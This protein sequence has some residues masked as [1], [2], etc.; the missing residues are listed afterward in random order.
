MNR[1][2]SIIVTCFVVM[3]FS[4]N[5]EK[6]DDGLSQTSCLYNY[7]EAAINVDSF[8]P[9]GCSTY[10][11]SEQEFPVGQYQYYRPRFNPNNPNQIA[12]IQW[13]STSGTLAKGYSLH[14]FDFCTGEH[15]LLV[16]E[17][18]GFWGDYVI[19]FDWGNND[20]MVY[21]TRTE[22]FYTIKADGQDETYLTNAPSESGYYKLSLNTAGNKFLFKSDESGSMCYI[23]NLGNQS[24]DTIVE[25]RYVTNPRG[26]DWNSNNEL[27]FIANA[28]I[29]EN[30]NEHG[31][32]TFNLDNKSGDYVYNP[33]YH[34]WYG[35]LENTCWFDN[36]Q[37]ILFQT[38]RS[39]CYTTPGNNNRTIIH[40]GFDN[41]IYKHI[42]ISPDG[43][44]ILLERVDRTDIDGCNIKVE[45][46][47]YLINI[48]GSDERKIV[49]PE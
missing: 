38:E 5:C 1:G 19:N 45:H 32:Y 10:Y 15:N 37:K 27:S 22:R 49:F 34:E 23:H 48:D 28:F 29:D 6:K 18:N 40:T 16:D 47:L 36:N 2:Y 43:Q 7:T 11:W 21:V 26:W 3:I 24:Q 12:Y 41:R 25:L 9:R 30:F 31:I 44:T 20:T 14:T 8:L 35:K 42:D 39:I 33:N 17:N 46:N 4:F 13:D